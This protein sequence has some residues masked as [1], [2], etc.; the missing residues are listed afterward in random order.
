MQSLPLPLWKKQVHDIVESVLYRRD[1]S[2]VY[3]GDIA[4]NRVVLR[5]CYIMRYSSDFRI[6]FP[7]YKKR[8]EELQSRVVFFGYYLAIDEECGPYPLILL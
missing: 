1:H 8:L 7:V 3:P 5:C 4:S 6:E 2:T